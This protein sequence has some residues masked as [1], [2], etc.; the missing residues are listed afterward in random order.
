MQGSTTWR[1]EML[2]N[3]QLQYLMTYL[4]NCYLLLEFI[5]KLLLHELG[6]SVACARW[7]ERNVLRAEPV[8][9]ETGSGKSL[10]GS[11]T[12][13]SSA[14]F[15]STL[16][17]YVYNIRIPPIHQSTKSTKSIIFVSTQY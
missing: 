9:R 2:G 12:L 4:N 17:Q 13:L 15:F 7:N 5:R 11:Q 16:L 3:I 1:I 10:A 8:Q 14:S 6:Y